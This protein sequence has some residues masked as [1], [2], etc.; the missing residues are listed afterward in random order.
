MAALVML[1]F[2]VLLDVA[3]LLGRSVDSR[4]PEYTLR[5]TSRPSTRPDRSG[6]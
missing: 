4:D 6:R 2:F 5:W 1:A 3:V